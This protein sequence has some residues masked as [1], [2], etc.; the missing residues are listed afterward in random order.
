MDR[1]PDPRPDA[2]LDG[3]GDVCATLTPRMKVKLGELE[4]GDFLEVRTDD[5]AAREGVPSWSRLTGN[6]LIKTLEED[7]RR[8]RFFVRKK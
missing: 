1:Q 2:V 4:S 7:D 8:T 5:P 6:D 3:L